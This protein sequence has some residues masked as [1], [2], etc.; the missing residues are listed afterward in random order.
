MITISQFVRIVY[1]FIIASRKIPRAIIAPTTAPMT[2]TIPFVII[3]QKFIIAGGVPINV[4]TP[5]P[6]R[7]RTNTI[8]PMMTNIAPTARLLPDPNYA[9]N[10]PA[11]MLAIANTS[12]NILNKKGY[13]S[14]AISFSLATF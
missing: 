9:V 13:H 8:N 2:A 11:T 7:N 14:P 1:A 12:I 6:H 10:I 5:A 3:P 4:R